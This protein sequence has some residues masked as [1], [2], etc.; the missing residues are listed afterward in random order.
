VLVVLVLLAASCA[1]PPLSLYTL[2]PPNALTHADPLTSK[3]PVIE[4]R[5]VVV[6]DFLDTQ[7]ILLRDGN[8]LQRSAHGRWASRLSLGITSYMTN[9]LAVR[10]P[11]A[12]VTDQPQPE[13]PDYRISLVF[14]R[15][16]VTT[17]GVATLEADWTVVPRNPARPTRRHRGRFTASGPVASDQ[18]VVALM[19]VVVAQLA[20]AIDV[21]SLR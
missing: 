4:I 15:L 8:T 11:D 10:R 18:D 20:D 5:R 6:P 7:D 12:L 21:A 3:A 16:D 2:E 19:Q 17:A 14:S 9:L 1:S 13:T